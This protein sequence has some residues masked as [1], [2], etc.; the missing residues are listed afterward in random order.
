MRVRRR[1]LGVMAASLVLLFVGGPQTTFTQGADTTG[2]GAAQASPAAL[3]CDL[4]D[5]K[6]VA[7]LTAS[8]QQDLLS[9]SWTGQDGADVRMRY[10]IDNAKPVVRDIAVRKQGGQ[11]ATLAENLSPEYHVVSGLRRMS[12]D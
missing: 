11:W 7:G 2:G 12:S 10:A 5:Y 6:P 1:Y 4:K 3:D 9:V 8:V